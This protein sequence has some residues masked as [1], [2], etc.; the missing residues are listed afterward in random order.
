MF[1]NKK[2][3]KNAKKKYVQKLNLIYY[4]SLNCINLRH[5]KIIFFKLMENN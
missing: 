1:L 5:K 3:F 4:A 2:Q